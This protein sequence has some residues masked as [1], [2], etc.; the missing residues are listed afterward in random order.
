MSP[1]HRFQMP[2]PERPFPLGPR[3]DRSE[4]FPK[5]V[6]VRELSCAR[7]GALCRYESSTARYPG[8]PEFL[9]AQ[10][11]VW[12]SFVVDPQTDTLDVV[13]ACSEECVQRLFRE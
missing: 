7:C 8:A 1:V 13:A 3:E 9:R 11:D 2:M 5:L 12:L 6:E 4:P 10:P